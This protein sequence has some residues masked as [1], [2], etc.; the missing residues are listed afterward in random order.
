MN[1]KKFVSIMIIF[2]LNVVLGGCKK[3]PPP[4][5]PEEKKVLTDPYDILVR[6]C[7]LCHD[8]DRPFSQRNTLEDW[9]LIVQKM[10]ELGAKAT[11]E[12]FEKIIQ[13]LAYY[14]GKGDTR[15]P[16]V[17]KKTI[18]PPVIDT[19]YL[20]EGAKLVTMPGTQPEDNRKFDKKELCGAC[21]GDY[22][23]YSPYDTWKGSMMANATRDLETFACIAI[24][25]K[26]F[27]GKLAVG[28]LCLR[29]H[30][31]K[32]WLEGRSE[33][34]DGSLLRGSDYDGVDCDFCHRQVDPFSKEGKTLTKDDV[35][36]R[37]TAQYV[38]NAES[39]L[40]Y[41]PYKDS[42][43]PR[44]KTRY[45][46]YFKTSEFCATCHEIE[47][48]VYGMKVPIEK[49][50]S[51][52][53]YSDFSKEGIECQTC[54]MPV[55]EGFACN[56]NKE[57]NEFFRK[58][59]P[60]HEF[61]GANAW[62]PL[63]IIE[64]FRDELDDDVIKALKQ[65]VVKAE[66]ML[67][68]AAKLEAVRNGNTLKVKVIN[69]TGHKLP[70]GYPEGRRMW[71]NVKF[72]DATGKVIKES[73]AYDKGTAVLKKDK[74]IKVYEAKPGTKGIE[75]YPDGPSFYFVLNNHIYKDNRIPPRGFRNAD[76]EKS[77]AYIKGAKYAD[78]QNWDIT[79]YEIP[80]GTKEAVVTMKY[81][82]ASKEY[83][84][85]LYEKNKGNNM[86]FF[87]AGEKLYRYWK[88]TGKSKPVDM[89]TIK[90]GL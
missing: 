73:G 14:Y 57:K 11:D 34:P 83:I 61:I 52:W 89:A 46:E 33:P 53:L 22:E 9:R 74:E 17:V 77:M 42:A 20:F 10:Q 27:E 25:N 86:D 66:A 31:P 51:E 59:L 30:T 76:Y 44:H 49:T 13:Y 1:S 24:Q 39:D 29:C 12:E 40:K 26:I 81:Q 68:T 70:T 71:I 47:N 43:S 63:V 4:K 21:H 58:R 28:D 18:A 84:E 19:S 62:M 67:K 60:K 41:G 50:Y 45:V 69:L 35:V 79:E 87:K 85:F 72:L 48:P 65:T 64:A 38:I 78:G 5:P 23:T 2:L 55:T 16:Q 36:R 54:H 90:V 6:T 32:G 15:P 56:V 88:E 37:G 7:T 80:D 82:T 75:G 8:L 3:E